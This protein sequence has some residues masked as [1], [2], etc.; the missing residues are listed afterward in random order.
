MDRQP[1]FSERLA[2]REREHPVRFNLVMFGV[3]AAV[4]AFWSPGSAVVLL[5][6]G[7]SLRVWLF[8]KGGFG[9]RILARYWGWDT[10]TLDGNLS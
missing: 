3:I 2:L 8:R 9:D 4:F 10:T 1:G 5:V 6:L 7:T